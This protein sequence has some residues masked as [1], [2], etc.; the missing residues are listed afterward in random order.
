MHAATLKKQK[1][2]QSNK[3]FLTEK[4]NNLPKS[5]IAYMENVQEMKSTILFW[6]TA[7]SLVNMKAK[8]LHTQVFI[9]TES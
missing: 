4:G 1:M 7:D 9:P 6:V 2:S 8:V 5:G 3:S